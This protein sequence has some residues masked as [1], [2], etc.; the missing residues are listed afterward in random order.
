MREL[1]KAY[2]E[3]QNNCGIEKGDI[4]KV[5]HEAQG[6]AMGWQNGWNSNMSES[7]GKEFIVNSI[8][9]SGIYLGG[10]GYACFILHNIKSCVMII[11]IS[12]EYEAE[13]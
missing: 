4:V 9:S 3:M 5:L 7:I 8:N 6:F 10:Y 12:S 2:L 1:E 11:K 13:V